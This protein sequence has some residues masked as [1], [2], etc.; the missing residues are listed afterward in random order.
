MGCGPGKLA[1]RRE[2]GG[3][4]FGARGQAQILGREFILQAA[5]QFCTGRYFCLV[6]LEGE[7]LAGTCFWR[8]LNKEHNHLQSH[9]CSLDPCR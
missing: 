5:A 7:Q 3:G 4:G 8:G 1:L 2:L 9:P 6:P